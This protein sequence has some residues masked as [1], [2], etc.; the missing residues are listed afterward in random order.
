MRR[1]APNLFDVNNRVYAHLLFWVAYYFYRVYMYIEYYEYS[2]VTQFVE[3]PVKVAVVYVHMYF[4]MPKLLSHRK[5][6]YYG[7]SLICLVFVATVLQSEVIRGMIASGIYNFNP[8]LLYAPRKFSSTASHITMILFVTSAIKILKD[9]YLQQQKLQQVEQQRLRNELTFLK[10]QINPHF[11]FNTLNNLYSLVLNK[12]DK[13][14]DAILKLSSL[15]E[16][17]IYESDKK[18]VSLQSEV[19]HLQDYVE[20]EKLRFGAE[21]KLDMVLP[22]EVAGYDIPP[23]LLIPLVENCFKHGKPDKNGLFTIN[24][25]ATIKGKHLCFSTYNTKAPHPI[26]RGKATSHYGVG[27]QNVMRRIELI[28]G[29]RAN[30]KLKELPESF[31]LTVQLPLEDQRKEA[32]LEA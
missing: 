29:K 2:P 4:L 11:F 25:E 10:T 7:I 18:K 9:Q 19:K 26:E 5:Y 21:L 27:L 20:L 16:Y 30:F 3:L 13:A 22:E 8:D 28:Y 15:M 6:F 31:S 12:S 17:V 14:A 24:I 32:P 1:L 23:M